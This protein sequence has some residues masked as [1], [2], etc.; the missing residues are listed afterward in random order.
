MIIV[1]T[2]EV[3]VPAEEHVSVRDILAVGEFRALLTSSA[4]SVLGDQVNRIAVAVLV[5]R[6]TGS[7]FVSA[8][9]IACSY[10]TWLVGGPF[11]SA[12]ADRW[13]RRQL[14]VLCDL[15]RAALVAL[16]V[17]PGVPLW[18]LF[19]VLLLVGVLAPPFDSA[20]SSV[21]PEVLTGERYVVGNAL[22]G[23]V[24]QSAS[25]AGFFLGGVL[26]SVLSPRG[27]LALDAATFV[28]SA[29]LLRAFVGTHPQPERVAGSLTRDALD[30]IRLVAGD[31]RLRR[32]LAFGILGSIIMIAP[33]GLAVPV[34]DDL[35]GGPVLA[36]VLIAALPSGFVLGSI[37]L[38]RLS[39]AS[40]QRLLAPMTAAACGPLL[41]S[42]LVRHA[43][44]LVALWALAGI[45]TAAQL[46]ANAQFMTNAAP[47]V[48]GRAYGV[49]AL[50]LNATSGIVLAATGGLAEWLDPRSAVAV[51]GAATLILLVLLT[52]PR[53]VARS[54]GAEPV[55]ERPATL[56]F[57]A[58]RLALGRLETHLAL[59]GQSRGPRAEAVL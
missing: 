58:P 48:R 21:L 22:Q 7:A 34:S 11:L 32:P 29:V 42:P 52:R 47:G 26:V 15:L 45:G 5:Y 27:A 37:V 23:S 6:S 3:K 9:T 36:G 59:S 2:A 44:T 16:L 49:A 53:R 46:I 14:M 4:L 55:D 20:K 19:S 54:L 13:P 39:A 24:I 18:A 1:H 57:P 40:R 41:L 51:A 33:E 35:G 12:L 10:L 31:P 17:L 30:G 8:A 38:M 50:G 28:A 56:P 43:P 25:L